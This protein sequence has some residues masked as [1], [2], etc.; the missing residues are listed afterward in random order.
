MAG[1]EPFVGRSPDRGQA[2]QGSMPRQHVSVIDIFPSDG[3]QLMRAYE[4]R[5]R[6]V[7]VAAGMAVVLCASLGQPAGAAPKSGTPGHV[8]TCAAVG[9]GAQGRA[10]KTLQKAVGATPDGDYGPATQKAVRK[11]QKAHSLPTSGVVD[12]AT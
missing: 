7:G 2:R 11:W 6:G 4:A 10:V 1:F 5:L 12:A 8:T 9:S 3:D